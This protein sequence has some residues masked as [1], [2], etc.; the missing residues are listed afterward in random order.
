MAMEETIREKLTEA[1]LPVSLD[2][3]NDSHRHAGHAGS[4]GTGESHFRV[5][6]ISDKFDGLSRVERHR[7]VNEALAVELSGPVHAL[8]I[9]ALA[10]DESR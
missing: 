7:L 4:P 5:T 1:F 9:K 10:P 6:I 2:V 8:A 3:V